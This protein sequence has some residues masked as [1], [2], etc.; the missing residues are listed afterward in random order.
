MLV[1]EEVMSF[2]FMIRYFVAE[3]RKLKDSWRNNN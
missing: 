1:A 2:E 3:L